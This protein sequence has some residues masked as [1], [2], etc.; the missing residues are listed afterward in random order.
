M[1]TPFGPGFDPAMFEHVPFF[2]ELG[3][4]LSWRGGPVNWDLARQAATGIAE[5][6]GHDQPAGDRATAEFADAVGVAELWLDQATALPAIDG[7]A[8]AYTRAEWTTAA[9]ASTGLGVYVE[10]V[11]Q[12]MAAAL[13]SGMPEEVRG[14]LDAQGS[15]GMLGQVMGPMG[16]LMYGLQMGVV[17]GHLAGQLL[18]TYDLGLPTLP[19]AAIGTVG[20]TASRFAADYD[21]DATEFRYWLALR[22]AAHRRMFAGVP[23]LRDRVAELIGRFA[24]EAEFDP[25]RLMEQLGG[26][27]GLDPSDPEAMQAM[28]ANAGAFELEP[29][30][31][32][33]TTLAQLQAVVAFVEA[34]GDTILAAAATERLP[35][36]ARIEEAILRR[37][38]ERGQGERF[39][40]QLVGLDLKPADLRQGRAFCDAVVAARG[41]EGLDRVWLD[42]T[43]LPGPGELTDPSRWLVRMAAAEL[44]T[45]ADPARDEDPPGDV[46]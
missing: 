16:A 41:Q 12:G 8:Q 32:Q 33:R 17:T 5:G 35:N 45:G 43:H 11:A 20:D 7:T 36:L 26:V 1:D 27:T 23:W 24:A 21:F 3:K 46:R 29:T 14:M 39:L 2:K 22:E 34:Y 13:T 18:G 9:A 6:H 38:A 37:R 40:Q 10:P 19:P 4:L 15:G 25:G 31:A 28:T 42:V 44:G 30:A